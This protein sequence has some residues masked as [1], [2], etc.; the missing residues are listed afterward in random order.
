V[1]TDT[2]GGPDREARFRHL[3]EAHYNDV[4]RYVG[5]RVG[6]ADVDD[7][8]AET[9]VVAWRRLEAVPAAGGQA[10]PW[11]LGVARN[12]T[13]RT[14]R[15]ERRRDALASKLGHNSRSETTA[16]G[17]SDP[18]EPEREPA[19]AAFARLGPDDREL[20][21]LISWDGVT[22]KEA[23][24]ILGCS[25]PTLRVRL[26]RARRRLQQGLASENTP[27]RASDSSLRPNQVI[28]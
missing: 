8:V 25:Q 27:A 5:R 9:F 21:A 23:A 6:S 20:L 24:R 10:K 18:P 17:A 26:H 3:F 1:P 15:S 19:L 16:A 4:R 14:L 7:V 2:S 13:S 11:L 12:V 22:V 28:T